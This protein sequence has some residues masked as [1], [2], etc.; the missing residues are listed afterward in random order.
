M[1]KVLKLLELV[2]I[3]RPNLVIVLT[4]VMS[5]PISVF[6]QRIKKTSDVI[7]EIIKAHFGIQARIVYIENNVVE[8]ELP[9]EGDWT[10]LPDGT[11]QPVNLFNEMV[12]LMKTNGDEIGLEVNSLFFSDDRIKQPKPRMNENIDETRRD[13]VLHRWSKTIMYRN[14]LPPDTHCANEMNKYQEQ[15]PEIAKDA[16]LPLMVE[17][18]RVKIHNPEQI[19]NKSISEIQ[20]QVW[21]CILNETDKEVLIALFHA[22]PLCYKPFLDYIA[23]GCYTNE[24]RPIAPNQ[25]LSLLMKSSINI[26]VTE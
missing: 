1:F 14:L 13:E 10:I 4:H 21:P 11:R 15:H 16:L 22:K 8:Y 17:L 12:H 3:C 26:L 2:D 7:Q 23:H 6:S 5:L 18:K 25:S 20:K 19:N 24:F 9:V